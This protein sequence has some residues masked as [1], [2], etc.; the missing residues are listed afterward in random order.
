MTHIFYIQKQEV[1]RVEITHPF[2]W[3]GLGL[4]YQKRFPREVVEVVS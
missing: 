1:F 3:V 4:P 2:A